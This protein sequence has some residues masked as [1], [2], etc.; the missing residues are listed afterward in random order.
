VKKAISTRKIIKE[1]T[2]YH[3]NDI[4]LGADKRAIETALLT[5]PDLEEIKDTL[6]LS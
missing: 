6:M 2:L 3:Y 5:N 1:G 4:V